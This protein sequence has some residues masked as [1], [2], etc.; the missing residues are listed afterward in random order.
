M[1]QEEFVAFQQNVIVYKF[2]TL[3]FV[4][5]QWRSLPGGRRLKLHSAKM[6]TTKFM[7]TICTNATN[8]ACSINF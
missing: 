4:L 1:K 8:S 7:I 6:S 5:I 3:N 2:L